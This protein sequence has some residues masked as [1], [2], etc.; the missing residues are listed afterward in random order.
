MRL[1]IGV[2]QLYFKK[3]YFGLIFNVKMEML[4]QSILLYDKKLAV[5]PS[6]QE[7]LQSLTIKFNKHYKLHKHTLSAYKNARVHFARTKRGKEAVSSFF[8]PC[9]ESSWQLRE[10]WCTR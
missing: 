7:A 6:P 1:S 3:K 9:S 5:V 2:L 4:K 10:H 8:L